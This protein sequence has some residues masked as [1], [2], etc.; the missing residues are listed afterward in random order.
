MKVL[1]YNAT[2]SHRRMAQ[3]LEDHL[4]PVADCRSDEHIYYQLKMHNINLIVL[5]YKQ[6][7]ADRNIDIITRIRNMNIDAPIIC[8]IDSYNPAHYRDLL[9]HGADFCLIEPINRMDLLSLIGAQLKRYRPL[10][11]QIMKVADLTF[12]SKAKK[13]TRGDKEIKL[14]KK[15]VQ[16]LEYFLKHHNQV[17]TRSQLMSQIWNSTLPPASNLVDVHISSLRKKLAKKGS[18]KFIKTVHGFGYKFVVE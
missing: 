7:D 16:L 8:I 3:F 2:F 15:E 18:P 14:K 17:I 5:I 10:V 1:L 4:Y 9:H 13:V 6:T 11:P 12:D